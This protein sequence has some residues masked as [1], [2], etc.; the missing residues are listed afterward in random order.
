MANVHPW[1]ANQSIDD[2][3]GWTWS[4]F[5]G[6]DVALAQSLSNK[7]DMSIAETGTCNLTKCSTFS[8]D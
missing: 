4:F 7:P 1:F 8:F 5:E 2:A 3:A 6:T